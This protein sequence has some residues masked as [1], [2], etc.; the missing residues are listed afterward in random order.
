MGCVCACA[1]DSSGDVAASIRELDCESGQSWYQDVS[2]PVDSTAID[3]EPASFTAAIDRSVTLIE[4]AF[5]PQI[6]GIGRLLTEN[7]RLA[8]KLA[9]RINASVDWTWNDRQLESVERFQKLGS[10]SCSLGEIRN[11]DLLV[12]W[13]C[14]VSGVAPLFRHHFVSDAAICLTTDS[15]A[16]TR[17]RMAIELRE[18]FQAFD[19]KDKPTGEFAKLA[20]A[21]TSSAYCV[22]LIDSA[23]GCSNREFEL[24]HRMVVALNSV[25]QVRL[26]DLATHDNFRGAEE[27]MTWLT[28]YPAAVRLSENRE[29]EYD[30]QRFGTCQVLADSKSDLLIIFGRLDDAGMSESAKSRLETISRIEITSQKSAISRPADVLNG[31]SHDL[32]LTGTF[33][34][35]D[36]IP[37]QT[38]SSLDDQQPSTRIVL[39]TLLAKFA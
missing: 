6:C 5:A 22:F 7:Q 25:T 37:F 27:A 20:R 1:V 36:G 28:G 24:V 32:N 18:T 16:D 12:S 11:A 39:E 8:I 2:G 10:V 34:R 38:N 33:F 17:Q 14:D 19:E 15:D 3:G 29:P 21:I 35:G 23:T 31:V 26:V 30:P 4:K 9:K 13:D